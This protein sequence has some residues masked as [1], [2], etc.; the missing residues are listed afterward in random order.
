MNHQLLFKLI[1]LCL[2]VLLLAGLELTFR[3]LNFGDDLKLFIEDPQHSDF[4]L[5][6]PIVSKRFYLH[7]E[8]AVTGT[9]D[10]F[11]KSKGDGI[12]RIFVLGESTALGFP[13]RHHIAFPALLRHRLHQSFD[14]VKIELVNL[15]LTGINS[16]ALYDLA[17]EIIK[18]DPD[19]VIVSMGHNEYY[20]ALGVGSTSNLGSNIHLIRF[21]LKLRRLRVVQIFH[22][23]IIKSMQKI[24]KRNFDLQLNLMERMVRK[25]EIPYQSDVFEKGLNQFEL[26]LAESLKKF[27]HSNVPVFF[28]ASVSNLRDQSPFISK[29]ANSIT[30]EKLDYALIKAENQKGNLEGLKEL[31]LSDT[32][33]ALT[34]FLIAKNYLDCNDTSKAKEHFIK[35]KQFDLLRFRAPEEINN[36][37]QNICIRNNAKYLATD[38]WMIHSSGNEIPGD[39]LFMEH[40]HPNIKGHFIICNLL[41]KYIFDHI[42]E[43]YEALG[44]IADSVFRISF[45]LNKVDSLY[46]EYVTDIL[47]QNWP[48][49]L[50]PPELSKDQEKSMEEALAGGLVVSQITWEMAME[51]LYKHYYIS[52][53]LHSAFSVSELMAICLPMNSAMQ[54]KAG[55][56]ALKIGNKEKA[57]FYFKSA[58]LWDFIPEDYMRIIQLLIH[59]DLLKES[60]FFIRQAMLYQHNNELYQKQFTMI[61]EIIASES[62]LDNVLND[63][64][65]LTKLIQNYMLIGNVEKV[66]LYASKLIVLNPDNLF[67]KH[68]MQQIE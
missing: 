66:K 34:H 19:L 12:F 9:S 1:A 2:P 5:I 54:V 68:I 49:N 7:E 37:A 40:V 61:K 65:K 32:T 30:N 21:V 47:K 56:L 29:S 63:Q 22:G 55:Q 64:S 46:G 38:Q 17:D 67:A 45:P 31:Y 20:G 8:N 6:N 15:S 50:T 36:I 28:L 13:Y 35:A 10:R 27:H 18:Q 58:L 24:E 23:A 4:L 14:N 53:D 42:N 59:S 25:Q 44:F 43:K 41:Y 51:K 26:N 52:E 16:Y 11:L 33:Y 62:E 57:L 48:F 60:L 3:L 39:D